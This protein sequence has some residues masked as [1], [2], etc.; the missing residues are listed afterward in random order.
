MRKIILFVLALMIFISC[1]KNYQPDAFEYNTTAK[2]NNSGG[3]EASDHIKIAVLS[4]IYYMHPLLIHDNAAAG[5]PFKTV[6]SMHRPTAEYSAHIFDEVLSELLQE[7]PDIVLI[8]GNLA[9]DGE[10]ISH[11]A[12]ADNLKRLSAA[13][14]KVYVA[15]GRYDVNNPR[16]AEYY[17]D[18]SARVPNVSPN[19][20][21]SIYADFGY[22]K[23]NS[24][25]AKD[26]N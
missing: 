1:K 4:D 8:S 17:F 26:P 20:F 21:K 6:A 2:E 18:H 24:V 14:I 13:G 3:S 12:V 9:L 7:H 11:Q 16:S 5:E 10:K 25:I 22:D 15:P 23:T 19:E